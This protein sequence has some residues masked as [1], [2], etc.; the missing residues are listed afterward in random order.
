MT[1]A[2]LLNELHKMVDLNPAIR[3]TSPVVIY[4]YHSGKDDCRIL[5]VDVEGGSVRLHTDTD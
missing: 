5:E 1:V 4:D 3:M 2:E